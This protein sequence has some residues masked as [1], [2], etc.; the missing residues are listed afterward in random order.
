MATRVERRRGD[1]PPPA[2]RVRPAGGAA[3]EAMTDKIDIAISILSPRWRTHLPEARRVCRRAARAALAAAPRAPRAGE[4]GLVLADDDRVRRLNR[5]YRGRDEPTNVLSFP[6]GGVPAGA[7]SAPL[8]DVVLALET[9]VAEAEAQGKRP[10]DHLSHLVVHG[11]LHL[12]GYDHAEEPEASEMERLEVAAL[13]GLGVPDPYAPRAEL[14][15]A[16]T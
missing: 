3:A 6:A 12:L 13:A 14:R 1:A 9:L 10:E 5:D 2:R 16:E 15:Q 8:G 11:V 4:L 7:A